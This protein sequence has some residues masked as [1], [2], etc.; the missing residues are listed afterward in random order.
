MKENELTVS[1]RLTSLSGLLE[2]ASWEARSLSS[3]SLARSAG[4]SWA[5]K[6]DDDVSR[7]PLPGA[8]SAAKI[9]SSSRS[10]SLSLDFSLPAG[11]GQ[12]VVLLGSA[13]D[14]AE[15]AIRPS[16]APTTPACS[17][18]W[19]SLVLLRSFALV[20]ALANFSSAWAELGRLKAR[21]WGGGAALLV[22]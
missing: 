19:L 12:L 14:L 13:R 10:G 16:G 3:S 20:L 5:G 8:S 18:S 22:G 17:G 15:T 4:F 7:L 9:D 1:S 6:S 21:N 2:L 11:V